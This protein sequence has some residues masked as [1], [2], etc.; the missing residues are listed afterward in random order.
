MV[1]HAASGAQTA[2]RALVTSPPGRGRQLNTVRA[3]HAY[4]SLAVVD[5]Y[6]ESA[7]AVRIKI[8]AYDSNVAAFR[9]SLA[10]RTAST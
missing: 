9:I 1:R 7:H 8:I 4:C 5:G 3:Q 10:C 2:A 6:Q